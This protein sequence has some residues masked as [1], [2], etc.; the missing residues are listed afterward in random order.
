MTGSSETAFGT[1]E[2][3]GYRAMDK[4]GILEDEK[5]IKHFQMKRTQSMRMTQNSRTLLQAWR[6]NCDIKLLLYFS[7]PDFPDIG[8]IEEVCRCVVEYTG[9][10]HHTCKQEKDLVRDLIMR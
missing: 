8:E 4:A 10:K 7:D 1:E 3:E 5:G 6:G 2:T 9:K